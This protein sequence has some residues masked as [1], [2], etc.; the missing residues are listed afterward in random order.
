MEPF[1]ATWVYLELS[2]KKRLPALSSQWRPWEFDHQLITAS[3]KGAIHQKLMVL[4]VMNN[5]TLKSELL[6][7]DYIMAMGTVFLG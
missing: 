7:V 6:K 3:Q 2:G 5:S 4:S 1:N